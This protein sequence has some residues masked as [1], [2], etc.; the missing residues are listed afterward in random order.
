MGWPGCGRNSAQSR[1]VE[2][3]STV[4]PSQ[5]SGLSSAALAALFFCLA[6]FSAALISS[7]VASLSSGGD[8][9]S[10]GGAGGARVAVEPKEARVE[11]QRRRPRCLEVECRHL[12][13]DAPEGRGRVVGRVDARIAR[14]DPREI[15]G[16]VPRPRCGALA[17]ELG[18]LELLVRAHVAVGHP[19][20]G[21][22]RR[23]VR[24]QVHELRQLGLDLVRLRG[25]GG[26]LVHSLALR[27]LVLRA[28]VGTHALAHL[29]VF[30]LGRSRAPDRARGDPLCGPHG[31]WGR[32]RG[33][34]LEQHLVLERRGRA[35]HLRRVCYAFR[36]RGWEQP[37]VAELLNEDGRCGALLV[38]REVILER[39]DERVV[40]GHES[41][42][43]DGRAHLAQ[44]DA[45]ALGVAVREDGLAVGAVPHVEL[46]ATAAGAQHATEDGR[47]GVGAELVALEVGVVARVDQVVAERQVHVRDA[48]LVAM[49]VEELVLL[50]VEQ[51]PAQLGA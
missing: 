21:L 34:A 7:L 19:W 24:A 5:P 29:L 23:L 31:R 37:Q 18:R 46:N 39:E 30:W 13:A 43:R 28:V 38:G 3:R 8:A 45:A 6:A 33:L 9:G 42:L 47:G 26:R 50:G 16:V 51:Q 25:P 36:M 17:L 1:R 22:G 11:L 44:I 41:L 20:L 15:V 32:R 48:D 35:E 27:R 49:P 40:R 2:T 12:H 10:G 4:P 14:V